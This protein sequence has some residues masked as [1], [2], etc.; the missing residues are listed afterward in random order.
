MGWSGELAERGETL[1][2]LVIYGYGGHYELSNA[3]VVLLSL[4]RLPT[5]LRKNFSDGYLSTFSTSAQ[6]TTAMSSWKT[7]LDNR[8]YPIREDMRLQRRLWTL[9]RLGWG[10]LGVLM[11]SASLGLFGSGPVSQTVAQALDGNLEIEYQ[12]FERNGASSHFKVSA[13]DGPDGKVWVV[14]G[15]DFLRKFT[16]ESIRPEPLASESFGQGLRLQFRPGSNGWVTAYFSVRSSEVGVSESEV[17]TDT[18]SIKLT[19]YI[20]P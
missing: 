11:L 15:G 13:K 2:R 19:Q 14:I 17:R 1:L 20:Y 6:G 18:S 3:S 8:N 10:L 9:E 16:I 4:Y 7:D 12:R 5:P